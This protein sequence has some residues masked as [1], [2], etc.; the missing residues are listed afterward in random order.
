M[1]NLGQ[2]DHF[3][4]KP[5][6][7][8]TYDYNPKAR[9][10]SGV[11]INIDAVPGGKIPIRLLPSEIIQANT[12]IPELT[13]Q[14]LS[15]ISAGLK[16]FSLVISDKIKLDENTKAEIIDVSTNYGQHDVIKINKIEEIRSSINSIYVASLYNMSLDLLKENIK[17]KE[18][19]KNTSLKTIE[20]LKHGFMISEHDQFF[21]PE[22]Q[23]K[24]IIVDVSD[25]NIPIDERYCLVGD[26]IDEMVRI[27]YEQMVQHRSL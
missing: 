9:L 19:H 18:N 5:P 25:K 20:L 7:N 6:S 23:G 14:I 24:F 21:H 10:P 22:I 15:A 16:C 26:D 1:D 8:L 13:D 3:S 17:L 4:M 27:S 2:Q 12:V 11:K